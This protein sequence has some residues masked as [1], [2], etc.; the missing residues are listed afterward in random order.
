MNV[1]STGLLHFPLLRTLENEQGLSNLG[2]GPHTGI[3][4]TLKGASST[5]MPLVCKHFAYLYHAQRSVTA[6]LLGDGFFGLRGLLA[7]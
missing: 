6:E 2:I 4:I 3:Q 5:E 7:Q 1:S